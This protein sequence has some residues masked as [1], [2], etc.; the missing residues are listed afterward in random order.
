MGKTKRLSGPVSAVI[1]LIALLGILSCN[2]DSPTKPVEPKDYPVYFT[3]G[4]GDCMYYEYHPLTGTLDSFQLSQT[5]ARQMWVS[6]D[7]K[8]LYLAVSSGV[9][10]IDVETHAETRQFPGANYIS[11]SPDNEWIALLGDS[12]VQLVSTEDYSVVAEDSV[13]SEGGT[14]TE[15][16]KGF[17]YCSEKRD[18]IG[19]VQSFVTLMEID[20]QYHIS[21]ID[22]PPGSIRPGDSCRCCRR[23]TGRS[24][25]STVSER[26]TRPMYLSMTSLL[27]QLYSRVVWTPDTEV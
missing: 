17:Y 21:R 8:L 9:V 18:S 2:D 12:T 14:F 26:T 6:A 20:N 22:L 1:V 7:G 4:S 11:V 13:H 3:D 15:D 23:K 10:A 5:Q 24:S 27:T 25:I 16:S 19:A